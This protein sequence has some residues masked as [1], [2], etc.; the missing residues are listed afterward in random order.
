MQDAGSSEFEPEETQ[1]GANTN[2]AARTDLI[3][4]SV[5]VIWNGSTLGDVNVRISRDGSVALYDKAA[6][7]ALLDPYLSEDGSATIEANLPSDFFV[8][9][10]QLAAL[11]IASAFS[12]SRLEVEIDRIDPR[13]LSRR[14][15]NA[16]TD[17]RN[18]QP[19]TVQQAGF[20]SYLNV[21][22]DL[23]YT[24]GDL[25]NGIE[26]PD[27]FAFGT[28][29]MGRFGLQY[30]GG[31]VETQESYELYRRAVTGVYDIEEKNLRI[32]AGDIRAQI[33][34]LLRF[35]E[36]GGVG[37]ERRRQIFDPFI[38]ILR[39]DGRQVRIDTPSTI[40]IRSGGATYRTIEADPGVYDLDDLPLQYGVND[41][42]VIVRDAAGREQVTDYNFF[43]DPIDLDVGDYEYGAYFGLL[44]EAGGLNRT[45]SSDLLA[46]GFYRKAFTSTFSAG[47]SIQASENTQ[48]A[49]I[50]ARI[51]PAA[52]IGA[53]DVDLAASNS[54]VGTGYAARAGWRF[55]RNRLGN[56]RQFSVLLDYE[57]AN[58]RLPAT[59][60]FSFNQS[61]FSAT[62]SA[63]QSIGPKLFLSAGATYLKRGPTSRTTAFTNGTY[64]LSDVIR[65]T[66][67]VEYGEGDNQ[68]AFGVRAGL[69]IFFGARSRAEV[70]G[71]SRVDLLRASYTRVADDTVG[72][73]GYDASV[74]TFAGNS[75]ADASARYVGNRFEGNVR[76]STGGPSIGNFTDQQTVQLQLG[77]S[78]AF[79]DGT[80]GIGRPIEDA[81]VLI[82]PH[83]T[84]EDGGLVVGRGLRDGTY[85]AKSGTFGAAVANQIQGYQL[86]EILYDAASV[87]VG[88]DVG[89]GVERVDIPTG[90]G[91]V[92][93]V[94]SDRFVSAIG[95]L[96]L[97]AEPAKLATGT[98]NEIDDPGFTRQS[99][100]TNSAGRFAILGLAPGKSYRVELRSGRSFEINVPE[101]NT[102]LLRLDEL[103]L[104]ESE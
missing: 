78:L 55:G 47:A 99:F 80:F 15:I 41:I 79:A 33:P 16:A 3:E 42:E 2:S 17:I 13:V 104:G 25:G 19:P 9:A 38:P 77:T 28:T 68:P 101:D 82:K 27:I 92:V 102:G 29:R 20:S 69:S 70:L 90:A 62:A 76:V 93:T 64:L 5:P 4:F 1:P 103:N 35:A 53:F 65:A 61:R 73:L 94:G 60:S 66:F 98:I 44:S 26:R 23:R 11:G 32:S 72:S 54:E 30:E 84:L 87:A 31:V 89:D 46:S 50:Q 22:M 96:L 51:I 43:Y 10:E 95:T 97:G 36:L 83:P 40:E 58:Y 63:T 91:A 74:Q 86:E 45:Y 49:A 39:L 12:L 52:S 71:R 59:T 21:G 100:F 67:G 48:A 88:Y 85:E 57:S 56:A 7:L 34:G 75:L 6:F 14:R 24:S 81:F 18:N 37:I 8:T